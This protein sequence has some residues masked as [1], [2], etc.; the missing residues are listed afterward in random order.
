M[1]VAP[2][3]RYELWI[4]VVLGVSMIVGGW[5][6]FRP[7]P[8][9][10]RIITL[11]DSEEYLALEPGSIIV[12][13]FNKPV[14]TGIAQR[15]AE[16]GV[17]AFPE[18]LSYWKDATAPFGE[19][20]T[21]SEKKVILKV[22]DFSDFSVPIEL[23]Y[24]SLTGDWYKVKVYVL[25]DKDLDR[26]ITHRFITR[27]RPLP[28]DG[29]VPIGQGT[30]G[31]RIRGVSLAESLQ[32][33]VRDFMRRR[34]APAPPPVPQ[35][36]DP[37]IDKVMGDVE[38]HGQWSRHGKVLRFRLTLRNHGKKPVKGLR[39]SDLRLGKQSPQGVQVPYA[40]PVIE[41]GK[42][43]EL[44]FDFPNGDASGG[45]VIGWSYTISEDVRE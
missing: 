21:V 41:P 14:P 45:L 33:T 22:Y 28:R 18:F 19:V 4:G 5:F 2:M 40:V 24:R 35:V 36:P 42:A 15:R 11:G 29:T 44:T 3:R 27:S 34:S 12:L 17:E 6:A 16:M 8:H 26:L 31:L 10:A 30:F 38:A 25:G 20:L 7:N 1:N 9:H 37:Y 32:I 39:L 43:C 13:E 23:S